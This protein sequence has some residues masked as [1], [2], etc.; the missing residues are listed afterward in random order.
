M[1]LLKGLLAAALLLSIGGCWD[2]LELEEQAFVV[3]LG[4]DQGPNRTVSVTFQI[5]NPQ[6]GTTNIGA[7]ENEPASEIVTFTAS[8][9]L[10]AKEIANSN[11]S[12][13]ISF[14][15]L[16]AIIVSE[17]FASSDLFHHII[18]S[19]IA[20][21]EM[22]REVNIII[23]KEKP[24]KFIQNNKPKL[25][26]R[27]HKYFQFMQTRWQENGYVPY[28][29][30]NRYLQRIELDTIFLTIYATSE[31]GEPE[32]S[33][34]EDHYIAG[35]VPKRGGDPVQMMGSAVF[36]GGKM[37]GMMTGE[38]TRW[39]VLL[40]HKS[41]TD[42]FVTTYQDPLNPRYGISIRLFKNGKTD[43]KM[44]LRQDPIVIDVTMPLRI[45][46]LSNPSLVNYATRADHQK[47]L[48][49]SLSEQIT[50]RIE[51]VIKKTQREYK[52]EPFLWNLIARTKFNT[53]NSY[54]KYD[55]PKHYAEAKVNVKVKLKLENFGKQLVPPTVTNQDGSDT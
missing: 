50:S 30:I 20:D 44:N 25:E 4:L 1:K 29:T 39:A 27:P 32:V 21:P 53:W 35:E 48:E 41:M 46:V 49:A 42:S 47:R 18:G 23:C 11:V 38:E 16:K 34:N 52:G 36:R 26:T 13:T 51:E 33:R 10:A 15:H 2:Q 9:I 55:W 7:A 8:D 14:A 31:P 3:V 43:V 22:R 28:S 37:I 6:V 19:A 12:R 24:E 5:A 54:Q 17:S 45:Q 40:R